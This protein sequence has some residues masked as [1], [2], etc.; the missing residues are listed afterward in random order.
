MLFSGKPGNPGGAKQVRAWILG[1]L[2]VLTLIFT[3]VHLGELENFLMLV[4]H[5]SPAWLLLALILQIA[6]YVC[7]AAVWQ[8]ALRQAGES[9]TLCSL[10]P[11][12]V[13]KLFSDQAL[14]SGGVSGAGLLIAVLN[15][16]GV[17][18]ERSLGILIH[19]MVG[20]YAA[21]LLVALA[22][23]LLLWFHHKIT[24]WILIPLALFFAAMV[25]LP[26]L[27]LGIH[28]VS[29][30]IPPALLQRWTKLQTFL[31]QIRNSRADVLRKPWLIARIT[32]LQLCV[33]L[34]DA[35]TLWVVLVAI[36]IKISFVAALPSFVIASIVA[37][38]S[39]IPLGLGTFEASCVG[40]LT[41][42]NIS[43]EAALTATL[44]LRGFTVWLPMLPGL[45][46]A[47]RSLR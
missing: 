7:A 29:R 13:A 18:A 26:F 17:S 46:L 28:R 14:P 45:W 33:F 16:R 10:V 22:S 19:S 5:A 3:V 27:V 2:L 8:Q 40:M 15:R 1:L 9:L 6:T 38:I 44:L 43:A 4:Q 35:L 23:L 47:R 32:L 31:E 21:Y 37:T 12:G 25:A 11:L 42:F 36:G 24:Q 30:Y 20:Y 39:P 41:M 34:L